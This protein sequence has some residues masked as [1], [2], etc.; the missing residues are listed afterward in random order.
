M[1]VVEDKK[2]PEFERILFEIQK[3]IHQAEYIRED[4]HKVS[5]RL[6]GQ[7]NPRE[8]KIEELRE[9]EDQFCDMVSQKLTELK[10]VLEDISFAVSRIKIEV[11]E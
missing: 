10:E 6:L 7:P 1:K 9:P 8:D 5:V 4:A 11:K 2:E 3:R